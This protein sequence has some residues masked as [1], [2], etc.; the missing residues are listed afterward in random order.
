MKRVATGEPFDGMRSGRLPLIWAH[1]QLI[2]DSPD[3]KKVENGTMAGR[4]MHRAVAMPPTRCSPS[5]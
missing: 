1:A 2:S 3:K 5:C 4:L